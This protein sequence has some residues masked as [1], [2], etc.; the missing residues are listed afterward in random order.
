MKF[1]VFCAFV[2]CASA[3]Q[4]RLPVDEQLAEIDSSEYGKNLLDTINIEMKSESSVDSI[5]ELLDD[6]SDE[7]N[8]E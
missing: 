3:S 4:L 1:V 7:L 8:L 2:L 6:L 5:V